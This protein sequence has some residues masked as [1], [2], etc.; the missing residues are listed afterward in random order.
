[1]GG[2]GSRK[3]E[4][5]PPNPV[6][7]PGLEMGGEHSA[8]RT[9]EVVGGGWMRGGGQGQIGGSLRDAEQRR[10]RPRV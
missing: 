9:A 10:V 5:A 1:M 2:L 3:I 8:N 4:A 7:V 6:S